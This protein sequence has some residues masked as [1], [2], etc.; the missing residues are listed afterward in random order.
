[1]VQ[2][3]P[4]WVQK[5]GVD[6][7][8]AF[9][10]EMGARFRYHER[11][12]PRPSFSAVL[13]RLLGVDPDFKVHQ[14]GEMTR[15]VTTEGEYGAWVRIDGHRDGAQAARFV[16]AVFM[17]DFATALDCIAI[18]P[19]HC[20]QLELLSLQILRSEA[21]QMGKRPRPFF[22]VPPI[23]W[24]GIPS[25]T[26]ANWYPLDFPNNLSNIVVPA[27]AFLETNG[28]SAIEAAFAQLG[29]G[30]TVESSAREQV[31]S[32]SGI[33]GSYFRLQGYRA[34]RAEPLHRELAM[35]VVGPYAYRMR[36]ETAMSAQLLELREL[37][38][39]VTGSFRPLPGGE[40]L[41]LG[42]A[43]AV[44]SNACDHWVS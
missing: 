38:R 35:F 26:T 2:F 1:M 14:V 25:G 22:Y 37:F 30:L 16:G 5:F 39:G 40:E 24:Q 43:F 21:F 27:A 17:E 7:V 10:P 12:R 41:R 33:A 29:A 18:L 42:R 8:T 31:S 19:K 32:A 9:P 4:E 23:G 11:L 28:E 3:P 44:P 34:G 13:D 20:A 36:L 6:L 15:I